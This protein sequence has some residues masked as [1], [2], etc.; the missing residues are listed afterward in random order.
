F[1]PSRTLLEGLC[2][3]KKAC[4]PCNPPQSP[5]PLPPE[6]GGCCEDPVGDHPLP[7][8]LPLAP[9]GTP[10]FPAPRHELLAPPRGSGTTSARPALPGPS[11]PAGRNERGA[12]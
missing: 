9:H 12:P 4:P 8:G 5:C 3:E 10:I 6:P 11:A 1:V 2:G 7:P